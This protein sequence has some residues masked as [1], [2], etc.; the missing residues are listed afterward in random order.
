MYVYACVCVCLSYRVFPAGGSKEMTAAVQADL[1]TWVVQQ[2]DFR[3]VTWNATSLR[4][5]QSILLAGFLAGVPQGLYISKISSYYTSSSSS[6]SSSCSCSRSR[7]SRV[8][9]RRALGFVFSAVYLAGSLKKVVNSS[10]AESNSSSSST[11][12]PSTCVKKLCTSN[13]VC[14]DVF[15]SDM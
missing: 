10:R 15:C 4:H 7:S 6:S 5:V 8:R 9:M 2:G 13:A 11:T 14:G 1:D 12:V 3:H